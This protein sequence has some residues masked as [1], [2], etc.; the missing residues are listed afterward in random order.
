M[1]ED[2]QSI[3]DVLKK[4]QSV[5][6]KGIDFLI[7]E[8]QAKMEEAK[9]NI[10]YLK[11]F[12]EPCKAFDQEADPLEVPSHIPKIVH[13]FRYIWLNS[14]HYNTNELIGNLFKN[15]SNQVIKY[16]LE[17]VNINKIFV[18]NTKFGID[19]CA[20][21]IGCCLTYKA[22]YE[23]M[24]EEHIKLNPEVGWPLDKARVFN[25]VDAFVERL[26]DLTDICKAMIVFARMDEKENIEM[27]RFCGTRGNEFQKT[28]EQVERNFSDAF[29]KLFQSS[30]DIILNV[31]K[32][33]W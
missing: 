9:S 17:K 31:H 7:S 4:S 18:G 30:K 26:N 24:S 8:C 16:C 25:H 10:K 20:Q 14:P 27:P 5:H 32:N 11:L 28:I 33:Q 2:V 15:L 12:V 6:I 1:H 3:L 19:M 29:D 23:R 13:I 22:L 21:A